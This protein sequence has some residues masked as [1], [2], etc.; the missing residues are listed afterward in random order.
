MDSVDYG[1]VQVQVGT[2]QTPRGE[3]ILQARQKSGREAELFDI[4][5]N[6]RPVREEGNELR[7]QGEDLKAMF[8]DTE[9]QLI[10]QAGEKLS[11]NR[12]KENSTRAKFE[13]TERSAT[14]P[15]ER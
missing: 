1:P 12:S 3:K 2:I 4:D 15:R 11:T 7:R 6:I 14:R 13:R 9:S 5:T 10:K 8:N